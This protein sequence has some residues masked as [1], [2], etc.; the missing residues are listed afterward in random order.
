[1]F[2]IGR[3]S[4]PVD[5]EPPDSLES[6][7]INHAFSGTAFLRSRHIK[8]SFLQEAYLRISLQP[9]K[10]VAGE[11]EA[12]LKPFGFRK[13]KDGSMTVCLPNNSES[14][15]D[16]WIML[17]TVAAC[18]AMKATVEQSNESVNELKYLHDRA[19][20][21]HGLAAAFKMSAEQGI[22]EDRTS[23]LFSQGFRWAVMKH[24]QPT[25][26]KE[27]FDYSQKDP[28][29]AVLGKT[30]WT[31][32]APDAIRRWHSLMIEATKHL[33]VLKPYNFAKSSSKIIDEH[34]K[35]RF[36]Y[37]SR[38]V[39]SSEEVSRMSDYSKDMRS[40]LENFKKDLLQ[41]RESVLP[42][43]RELYAEA[44][45]D[46]T[47]YDAQIA[48]IAAKRAAI[49]FSR[50]SKKTQRNKSSRGL[51]REDRVTALPLH[52]QISVTNPSGLFND[53]RVEFA[54]SKSDYDNVVSLSK[55]F[56]RWTTSVSLKD[57]SATN[58]MFEPWMQ[59]WHDVLK[60]IV[61]ESED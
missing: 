11:V 51:T 48:A 26:S 37:E 57:T 6:G 47:V 28:Y 45:K 8:E 30:V 13:E 9:G 5:E 14:Y 53:N 46:I 34:V 19:E 7:G 61:L 29:Y 24:L 42:N 15:A 27:L 59:Y 49:I 25:V 10:L 54:P 44:S 23:G 43:F 55:F 50:D 58:V 60:D 20:Y 56:E 39:F 22:T 38:A 3:T 32:D 12:K 1:L 17:A 40:H 2:W 33:R 41:D 4:S 52:L 31:G 35:H 36:N 16:N 21:L 18:T